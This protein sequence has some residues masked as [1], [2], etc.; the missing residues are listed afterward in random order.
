MTVSLT[1]TLPDHATH[2][3]EW[4]GLTC[5]QYEKLLLERGQYCWIC[6]CPGEKSTSAGKL[7]I[8]HDH[9]VGRWAVR[10]L[11]C[12][13]HNVVL[14][15][16]RDAPGWAQPY[17]S[18]LWYLRMLQ[19]CGLDPAPP[20]YDKWTVAASGRW[21]NPPKVRDFKGRVW[22]WNEDVRAWGHPQS[23]CW[24][25]WKSLLN[26]FGPHNLA[27]WIGKG[28]RVIT[29]DEAR[30]FKTGTSSPRR[31]HSTNDARII[32]TL[33]YIGKQEWAREDERKI[34]VIIS[35]LESGD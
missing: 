24:Y 29:A 22:T 7:Y 14:R 23:A 17:L 25:P 35:L 19:E 2:R 13:R 32:A 18:S 15:R 26:R 34:R 20:E 4:Y 28:E 10:G 33:D 31:P 8:D 5:E 21:A 6:G 1:L 27:P 16:D 3:H 9:H 30:R 12:H 11:L